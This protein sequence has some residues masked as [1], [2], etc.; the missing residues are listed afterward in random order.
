MT[1]DE[2]DFYIEGEDMSMEE[3]L[4]AEK[5]DFSGSD[6][7]TKIISAEVLAVS[8]DDVTVNIG[9]K[10]EVFIPIYEFEEDGVL[11]VKVGDRIDVFV[12]QKLGPGGTPRV[13]YKK[14]KE[15]K[16]FSEIKD[17]YKNQ[18]P[19]KAKVTEHNRGGYKVNIGVTA[20]MPMSQ[21]PYKAKK[22]DL[23]GNEIWVYILELDRKNRNIIVSGKKYEDKE[24]EIKK[25]KLKE[26]LEEGLKL[27]GFVKTIRDYGAFIDLGGMDALLHI[28]DISWGKIGKVN[29]VLSLGDEVEVIVLK[30]DAE[31]ERIAVGLKQLKED[32]WNR[33]VKELKI[34][35]VLEGKVKKILNTGALVGVK[36]DIDGFIHISD[37]SWVKKIYKVS[38]VLSEGDIVKVKILSV[39]KE[40][41][42]MGLGLKQIEES[43]WNKAKQNYKVGSRVIGK[44]ASIVDFGLFVTLP[45]DIQGMVHMKDIAWENSDEDF[46][47]MFQVGDEVEVVILNIDAQNQRISLGLKQKEIDPL[48]KY[49]LQE[50]YKGTVCKV[51]DKLVVLKLEDGMEGLIPHFHTG[52]RK[53]VSLTTKFKEGD[54]LDVKL[55]K[56]DAKKRE[57]IFSLKEYFKQ[58]EKE[59]VDKYM[60]ESDF[61]PTLGDLLEKKLKDKLNKLK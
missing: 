59:E 57:L 26:K 15:I 43:P 24:N 18:E 38:D 35:D 39:D 52:E 32:P 46:K 29:D 58:K 5:K 51:T 31:K 47:E 48:L 56:L 50:N 12:S 20:F 34:G 25:A 53:D 17:K 10:S 37:L 42:K 55:V 22:V 28:S 19:I 3:L 2:K 8:K 14:A 33:I 49:N 23:L 45:E 30:Y 41:K 11:G 21:V 16:A 7:G 1:E 60:E 36:D 27:K 61:N 54:V 13:S 4:A 9:M 6:S 40:N 44:V